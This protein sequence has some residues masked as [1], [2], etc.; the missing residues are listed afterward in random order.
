MKNI[1][2]LLSTSV[3]EI[4]LSPVLGVFGMREP[5]SEKEGGKL[6][7]ITFTINPNIT[8][9]KFYEITILGLKSVNL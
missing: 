1:K 6:K 5:Y 2:G 4:V 8:H 9:L 3:Q 7:K